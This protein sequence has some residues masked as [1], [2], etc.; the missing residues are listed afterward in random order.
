M[1]G[2]TEGIANSNITTQVI[3]LAPVRSTIYPAITPPMM[4][5]RS[6]GTD[7]KAELEEDE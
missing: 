2:Q 4:P 1:S 3:A 7:K 5:P 6:K